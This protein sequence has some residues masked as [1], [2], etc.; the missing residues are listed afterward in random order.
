MYAL[1]LLCLSL[2]SA[3]RPSLLNIRDECGPVAQPTGASPFYQPLNTCNNA[4]VE[5]SITSAAYGIFI[6]QNTDFTW[7]TI[8]VF[9]V[10]ATKQAL[11]LCQHMYQIIYI[12][13][14]ADSVVQ[15]RPR[16]PHSTWH[17]RERL[18]WPFRNSV[19]LFTCMWQRFE[20]V[21]LGSVSSLYRLRD[22]WWLS[23]ISVTAAVQLVI[24]CLTTTKLPSLHSQ[25]I[26]S[27]ISWYQW[28]RAS[29]KLFQIP[30]WT[31]EPASML[32][33]FRC[34]LCMNLAILNMETAV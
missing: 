23:W 1:A 28:V 10:L 15:L 34:L 22:N 24:G 17:I 4:V 20:S 26:V 16:R 6:D 18:R 25:Q 29:R 8:S 12:G 11:R 14:G 27:M 7:V 13:E 3:A 30:T 31:I 21:D 33:T 32:L 2:L 9:T 19:W 5:V